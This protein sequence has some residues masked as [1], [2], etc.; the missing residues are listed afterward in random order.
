MIFVWRHILR[1]GGRSKNDKLDAWH[2]HP[3]GR[4]LQFAT[5]VRLLG[6]IQHGHINSGGVLA[7]VNDTP[8]AYLA[9]R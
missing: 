4:C 3:L 7:M 8:K 6:S 9:D 5:G 1:A 2:Q